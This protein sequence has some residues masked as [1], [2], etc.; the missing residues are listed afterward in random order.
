MRYIRMICYNENNTCSPDESIR[1]KEADSNIKGFDVC[2]KV[3]S[4]S[5]YD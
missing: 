4:G 5:T 2:I 3:A 1:K